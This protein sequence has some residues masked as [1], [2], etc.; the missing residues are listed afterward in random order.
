MFTQITF[1]N[2]MT[3]KNVEKVEFLMMMEKQAVDNFI[4]T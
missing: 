2:Q 1:L 4:T 3:K